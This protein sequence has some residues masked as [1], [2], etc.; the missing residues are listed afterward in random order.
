MVSADISFLSS[1]IVCFNNAGAKDL[2]V[3]IACLARQIEYHGAF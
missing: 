1:F 2:N 3:Q